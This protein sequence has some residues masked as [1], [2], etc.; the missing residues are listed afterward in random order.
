MPSALPV[1]VG[2]GSLW[3]G[4]EHALASQLSEMK[5]RRTLHLAQNQGL[6]SCVLSQNLFC[7]IS[8]GPSILFEG[9]GSFSLQ[10]PQV[11]HCERC[12]SDDSP[13][14]GRR[15]ARGTCSGMWCIVQAARRI[16][17]S[18]ATPFAKFNARTFAAQAVRLSAALCRS[19][20]HAAMRCPAISRSHLRVRCPSAEMAA[21]LRLT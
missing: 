17:V 19:L 16:G 7:R 5:A 2:E 3:S 6:P 9:F 4:T 13:H 18:A 8:C 21:Q 20:R 1:L 11:F 14:P 12:C 15:S 10:C